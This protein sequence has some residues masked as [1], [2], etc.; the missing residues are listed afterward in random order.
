MSEGK[1]IGFGGSTRWLH[2]L[3]ALLS[4]VLLYAC[5]TNDMPPLEAMDRKVDL[6]RFMGDWYVIGFIPITLPFFSEE[7]A[8]NGV[9]SYRLTDAGVIETTYTFREGGF[10]GPEKRFTPKG[11]VYDEET[12]AEWRMQFLWPFKAAYL[13]LYLDQDYQKTIIGV[14][15]RNNVWIMSRDPQMSDAE[16]ERMLDYAAS[17]GYATGK[18]RRV[19]QRWPAE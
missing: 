11:W 5:A 16:Y 9:E 6:E 4:P 17:V 1:E 18:V 8:H 7:G 12:N 10:D 19:P 3:V 13:I 2:L 14:P 15:D